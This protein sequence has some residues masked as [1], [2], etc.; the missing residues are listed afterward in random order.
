MNI[1]EL[2]LSPNLGGLELY[3]EK[4]TIELSKDNE[5]INLINQE[6]ALA[7]RAAKSGRDYYGIKKSFHHFPLKTALKLAR[8]VDDFEADIIHVHWSK[9]LF[10]SVLTKLFSKRKPKIIYHRQMQI[11]SDKKG[12]YH[13]FIFKNVDLMIAITENLANEGRK[14]L[15]EFFKDKIKT[16]Y[17]G[18]EAPE[19]L[20][21]EDEKLALRSKYGFSKEDFV[22]GLFGRIE[23]IKGQYLLIDAL[24]EL[25]NIKGLIVGRAMEESYLQD[26]KKEAQEKCGER[27]AFEDFVNNPGELMECCD[28][29][30]LAT[31]NE[32]FGLVLAEAMLHRVPIIGS[33]KG[34]VP[35]IVGADESRGLMFESGNPQ[36]L[37]SKIL[38]AFEHRDEMKAK[39]EKAYEFAKKEFSYNEHFEKLKKILNEQ[40]AV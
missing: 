23:K 6:G 11:P 1:L 2:C 5:V 21:S 28:L 31:V 22:V 33:D 32:T 35:E 38:Y 34:G 18:V 39:E 7:G 40:R 3:A 25:Q 12:F 26:L 14:F 8:L 19:Q 24:Q 20:L 27:V 13:N 15:P 36:D 10:L 4:A 9:D 16:L 29:I 17:Y 30:L 37:K